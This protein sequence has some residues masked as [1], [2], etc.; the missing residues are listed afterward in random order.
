[1]A[2]EGRNDEGT[3]EKETG[4]KSN[5]EASGH[6]DE[7]EGEQSR[8]TNLQ[9]PTGSDMHAKRSKNVEMK[10]QPSEDDLLD[11]ANREDEPQKGV[12]K[13]SKLL[14]RTRKGADDKS[15]LPHGDREA[16]RKAPR[17]LERIT[18]VAGNQKKDASTTHD[19]VQ[20]P[21]KLAVVEES[22]KNEMRYYFFLCPAEDGKSPY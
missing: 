12:S 4:K 5:T 2:K 14:K 3:L 13:G 18:A 9:R 19:Q 21:L 20:A 1:M 22:A 11:S 8:D 10:K 16:H 7:L 17:G 6:D 15:V